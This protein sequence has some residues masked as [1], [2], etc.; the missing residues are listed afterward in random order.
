MPHFIF[1]GNNLFKNSIKILFQTIKFILSLSVL[2]LGID[3]SDFD[4]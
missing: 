3:L 4:L 2:E 1:L